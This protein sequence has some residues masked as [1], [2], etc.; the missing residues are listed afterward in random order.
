MVSSPD[1]QY[2]RLRNTIELNQLLGKLF[3]CTNAVI[4]IIL[5]RLTFRNRVLLVIATTR[6]VVFATLL[7]SPLSSAPILAILLSSTLPCLT[8]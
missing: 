4:V 5:V 8:I 3:W 7:L 1:Q 2:V 6:A